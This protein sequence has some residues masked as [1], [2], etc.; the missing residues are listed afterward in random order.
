L[1]S[2]LLVPVFEELFCRGYV[3]ELLH[4]MPPVPGG[5]SA[6]LGM[7]MDERPAP[8]SQPPLDRRAVYGSALIFVLGH[9]LAAWPAALA[10]FA[11]T[12]LL[13]RKTR[14]FRACVL[15]HACVNLGIALLVM[16]VPGMRF[17]WY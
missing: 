17:L 13:Y 9:P 11:L 7:R 5:F 8:L 10:Y 16:E 3:G 12:T 2:V 14:S 6:R 4:G 15:A 1:N